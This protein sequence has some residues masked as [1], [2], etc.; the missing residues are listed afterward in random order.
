MEWLVQKAMTFSS[1]GS[2]DFENTKVFAFVSEALNIA[3]EQDAWRQLMEIPNAKPV[4]APVFGALVKDLVIDRGPGS[5]A[6][7]DF[8]AW[9]ES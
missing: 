9:L 7:Q 6:Y 3:D 4:I 5:Q 1:D 8:V 2:G